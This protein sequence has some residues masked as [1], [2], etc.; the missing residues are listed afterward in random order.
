MMR[1]TINCPACDQEIE[2]DIDLGE[3]FVDM[4]EVCDRCGLELSDL[5]PEIETDEIS[6][7]V[8]KLYE[9]SRDGFDN[10]D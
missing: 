10:W 8:D 2:V 1:K 9:D 7:L 4:P 5:G 3:H 6:S